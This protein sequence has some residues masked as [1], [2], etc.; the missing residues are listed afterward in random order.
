MGR[1][2]PAAPAGEAANKA[3]LVTTF[4]PT[5]VV[6]PGGATR[7]PLRAQAHPAMSR[8][9]KE[10]LSPGTVLTARYYRPRL[11]KKGPAAARRGKN[12]P[13]ARIHT[14]DPATVCFL[15]DTAFF[16]EP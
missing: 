15:F 8:G 10:N 6:R 13:R 11:W 2:L 12:L 7:L 1:L 9:L 3:K 16:L 5:F 4:N 14:S